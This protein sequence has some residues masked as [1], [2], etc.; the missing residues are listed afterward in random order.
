MWDIISRNFDTKE[1]IDLLSKKLDY[2]ILSKEVTLSV[3]LYKYINL[4]PIKKTDRYPLSKNKL[5]MKERNRVTFTGQD[6]VDIQKATA[7]NNF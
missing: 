5:G 6:N 2:I 3:I 7:Q 4:N 1:I